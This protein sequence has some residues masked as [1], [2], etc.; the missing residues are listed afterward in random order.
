MSAAAYQPLAEKCFRL[1][2][3]DIDRGAPN[4]PQLVCALF[5]YRIEDAPKYQA[6]SYCWGKGGFTERIWCNLNECFC[7]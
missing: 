5:P 6:L 4:G 1:L 2:C 7:P 3:I